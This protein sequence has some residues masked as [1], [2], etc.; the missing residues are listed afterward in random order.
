MSPHPTPM[1]KQ[2]FFYKN[3]IKVPLLSGRGM[4]QWTSRLPQV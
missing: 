2:D 1:L 3:V 4:V